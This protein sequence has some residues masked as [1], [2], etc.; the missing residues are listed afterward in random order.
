MEGGKWKLPGYTGQTGRLQ[1]VGKMFLMDPGS[2]GGRN[3][4]S[5]GPRLDHPDLLSTEKKNCLAG[6]SGV[7]QDD[8]TL[9]QKNC[10][11]VFCECKFLE[12]N[13]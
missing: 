3:L 6:S 5:S 8:P 13:G 10:E 7:T 9:A 4:G 1:A 2:S 12:S 11:R